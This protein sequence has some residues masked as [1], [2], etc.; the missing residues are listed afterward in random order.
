MFR[1]IETPLFSQPALAHTSI[2][3][4]R[5]LVL[6][7]LS[8]PLEFVG[9]YMTTGKSILPSK[10]ALA[11]SSPSTIK[12]SCSASAKRAESTHARPEGHIERFDQSRMW[13][14]EDRF[15]HNIWTSED[16]LVHLH[17]TASAWDPSV[18]HVVGSGN[19]SPKISCNKCIV[20]SV[21]D[22]SPRIVESC[23]LNWNL[24]V[25][26]KQIALARCK[27]MHDSMFHLKCL[28]KPLLCL[29]F[30][31][32]FNFY[33]WLLRQF[34]QKRLNPWQCLRSNRLQVGPSNENDIS[35]LCNIHF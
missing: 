16:T 2:E 19:V 28:L 12:R 30:I 1:K 14:P 22:F 33:Q 23:I 34:V 17:R 8:F 13:D 15:V 31:H 35:C 11:T 25:N 5:T 4:I 10:Y 24:S 32:L 27:E 9:R 21:D 20:L 6:A 29:T 3:V 18:V 26:T 7:V